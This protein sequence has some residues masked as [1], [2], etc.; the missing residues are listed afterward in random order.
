MLFILY[1]ADRM[2]PQTTISLPVLT[3]TLLLLVVISSLNYS[4]T[5][6]QELD[7]SNLSEIRIVDPN[8]ILVDN[9]SGNLLNNMS[10]V[11]MI[12]ET[13]AGTI[14]D[15]ISKLLLVVN[16]ESPIKFSILDDENG[17]L[18]GTLSTL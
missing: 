18:S 4:H 15:G 16:Y 12:N 14:A 3:M 13:R 5:L 1:I 17:Q 6:A 7:N 9:K 10:L 11:T 2:W 8:P